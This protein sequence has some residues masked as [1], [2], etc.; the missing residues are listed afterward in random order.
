MQFCTI[1][2]WESLTFVF[3]HVMVVAVAVAGS[4]FGL[5][6]A[7]MAMAPLQKNYAFFHKV[8]P[9]SLRYWLKT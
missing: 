7:P 9:V 8:L 5:L 1:F 6:L 4:H 3:S 2:C